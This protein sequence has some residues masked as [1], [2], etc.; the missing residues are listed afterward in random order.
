MAPIISEWT[1]LFSLFYLLH[2][3]RNVMGERWKWWLYPYP[4]HL[5]NVRPWKTY[6]NMIFNHLGDQH[7]TN[8]IS[9]PRTCF[10]DNHFSKKKEYASILYSISAS[11]NLIFVLRCNWSLGSV[12]KARFSPRAVAVL[13]CDLM[14]IQCNQRV[15]EKKSAE[16]GLSVGEIQQHG[17][18]KL[19]IWS[20][21]RYLC[22]LPCGM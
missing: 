13:L 2:R 9:T 1:S 16:F 15:T 5:C 3:E 22:E 7:L 18:L 14:K 19:W 12:R 10:R 20:K 21:S 17:T 6:T 4:K 8:D 11:R